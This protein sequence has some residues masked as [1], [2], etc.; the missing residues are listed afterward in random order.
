M[1]IIN[2]W[3]CGAVALCAA[4]LAQADPGHWQ[5]ANEDGATPAGLLQRMT[6]LN[7]GIRAWHGPDGRLKRVYGAPV[8]LGDSPLSS[9]QAWIDTWGGVWNLGS[10]DLV[11]G[12]V[13]P[14]GDV[15]L[16]LMV[17]DD[18]SIK[19]HAVYFTQHIQGVPIF[20]G[21]LTLLTSNTN[22]HPVVMAAGDIRDLTGFDAT[23]PSE[24]LTS[25]DRVAT[26]ARTLVGQDGVV[27]GPSRVV[28]FAGYDNAAATP[29]MAIDFV[30][31]AGSPAVPDGHVRYRF[32]VDVI[33][34]EVLY[35]ED[36]ILHCFHGHGTAARLSS[37]VLSD[38]TGTVRA[39]ITP[40]SA[41]AACDFTVYTP[42]PYARVT[43]GGSTVYT[44][45]FGEFTSSYSGG[46]TS[47][48]GALDGVYFDVNNESGATTSTST[49]GADGDDITI[50][51]NPSPTEL[52]TAQVNAYLEANEIRDLVLQ[53]SPSF[54]TIAG[55][56][57][58]QINVNLGSTCNAYYDYSSI[59]FYQSGGGCNNTAFSVIVHHEYGHHGVDCAGSGQGEYGEGYGDV[60]GVILTGDPK[61]ARGFYANDCENGIR[62]ADNDCQYSSSG[63]SSC[64]SAIHACG[65][66]ISGVVWDFMEHMGGFND[67]AGMDIVRGVAINSM[68]L[69]S[70][71]SI[72]ADICI[73]YLVL[74]DNDGTIDNGTPNWSAITSAFDLHGIDTPE[75]AV[76]GLSLPDGLPNYLST[77]GAGTAMQL[78]IDNLAGSY[79]TGSGR[80]HYALGGGSWEMIPLTDIGGN[81]HEGVIP[82]AE[83]GLSTSFYFSAQTISG[84]TVLLPSG[85]AGAAYNRQHA[86]GPPILT[87]EENFQTNVGWES[88]GT[89]ADGLWDFGTP[90]NCNRGDPPT[91]F[92]GNNRCALTDNSSGNGCN[93]DVD[94]GTAVL[95]SPDLDAT[96]PGSSV[97]YARWFSNDYGAAPNTDTLVVTASFNGGATWTGVEVVGP[98]GPEVSGGWYV[99]EVVLD[100]LSGYMP[101]DQFRLRFTTSDASSSGSVV[102][103]AIDAISILGPNCDD[104]PAC[105]GDLNGDN[106]VDVEDVL[107][108]I[109]GFG[110][111]YTV[112]DL[113]E[114]LAEY[115]SNC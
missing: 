95:T 61:L 104:E 91:D 66:L 26:L 100:T 49:N 21:R 80:M 93:S 48:G 16:P 31:E 35:E 67:A 103:A 20:N 43:G 68:M 110:S 15:V 63:C 34:G 94:D 44:D 11:E 39:N 1:K 60:W 52:V 17:N 84:V 73:D 64:G 8:G 40:G 72:D 12:G 19:F 76:L 78:R 89:A 101:T 74:D 81:L 28:V 14:S 3:T 33:S 47:F 106:V 58:F 108:C 53:Y 5:A 92:D 90:V 54:P 98:A 77:G 87:Y 36:Q 115:G 111:V 22:G 70:G 69:H 24:L 56:T 86:D 82:S 13:L 42:L 18:G 83:C 99:H 41:A 85:G 2:A 97:R 55:Q 51:Y 9:A 71:T 10:K 4:V 57:N 107:T 6:N 112:D 96:E 23:I 30:A 50:S 29:T 109:A 27:V 62:N 38:V 113:L 75:L 79:Q 25:D 114:V 32:V 88:T 7:P 45:A 46:S 37:A 105:P 59:N 102:E 65:Q